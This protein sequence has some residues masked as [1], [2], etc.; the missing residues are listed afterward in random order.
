MSKQEMLK[1]VIRATCK[2]TDTNRFFQSMYYAGQ[3]LG[4]NPGIIKMVCDKQNKCKSGKS[5][6][7]QMNY[8]FAYVQPTED[9]IIEKKPPRDKNMHQRSY[10]NK[11]K[12]EINLKRRLSCFRKYLKSNCYQKGYFQKAYIESQRKFLIKAEER[13]RHDIKQFNKDKKLFFSFSNYFI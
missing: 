7:D 2:E 11:H 12:N 10:Y 6:K 3:Q 13:L 5:K 1:Q 8:T 9:M 4:I